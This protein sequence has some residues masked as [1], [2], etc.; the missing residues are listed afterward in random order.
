MNTI[1]LDFERILTKMAAERGLTVSRV[2]GMMEFRGANVCT[3]NIAMWVC[4]NWEVY[5]ECLSEQTF[6]ADAAKELDRYFHVPEELYRDIALAYMDGRD[7]DQWVN[8]T[9]VFVEAGDFEYLLTDRSE[10]GG[11]VEISNDFDEGILRQVYDR[12]V[13]EQ[14]AADA[15]RLETEQHLR[16]TA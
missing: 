12:L 3:V 13:A 16:R 8:G 6:E 5:I 1:T 14:E 10:K 11:W 9:H 2:K 7:F 15:A 4:G